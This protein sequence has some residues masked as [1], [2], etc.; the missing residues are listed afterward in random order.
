MCVCVVL[1]CVL[2]LASTLLCSLLWVTYIGCKVP[3]QELLQLLEGEAVLPLAHVPLVFFPAFFITFVSLRACERAC[4]FVF[5]LLSPM[6]LIICCTCLCLRADPTELKPKNAEERAD[7][8]SLVGIGLD[9]CVL[10]T[11]H[12]DIYLVQ[13]TDFFYPL[14]DDP[15]IQVR[16]GRGGE[17]ERVGG[18][19]KEWEG[20]KEGEGGRERVCVCVV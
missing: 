18:R 10:K 5:W 12:K 16:I 7:A 8:S 4:V 15:Y 19:K 13:T 14:V 20:E 11:R 2:H 3:Q 17:K 1:C 9:S 6:P